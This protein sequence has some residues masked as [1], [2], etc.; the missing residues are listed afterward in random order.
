MVVY[1]LLQDMC[2]NGVDDVFC[3][4]FNLVK[5]DL[6]YGLLLKEFVFNVIDVIDDQVQL[7]VDWSIFKVWL[8]FFSFCIMVGLVIVMLFVFV[9]LFY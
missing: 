9:V 1:G 6:G 4:V 2:E 7:A 8:L 3:E 5:D